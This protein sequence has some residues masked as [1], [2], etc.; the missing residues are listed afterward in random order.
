MKTYL[1]L[2]TGALLATFPRFVRA[3]VAISG[4]KNVS[5]CFQIENLNKFP[6][7]VFLAY[8]DFPRHSYQVIK[9]GDCIVFY[10]LSRPTLYAIKKTEFNEADAGTTQRGQVDENVKAYFETNPNLIRSGIKI[11]SVSSLSDQNPINGIADMLRIKALSPK[12]FDIAY[13][14]VIYTYSDGSTEEKAYQKQYERPEASR[15]EKPA[16]PTKDFDLLPVVGALALMGHL[17]VW[18]VRKR[19]L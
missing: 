18:Y 17:L 10:K 4:R 7:Y 2:L 8:Y 14:R 6:D 13:V 15:K 3:D 1:I 19:R 16:S 9:P 11:S 5:Y 12:S